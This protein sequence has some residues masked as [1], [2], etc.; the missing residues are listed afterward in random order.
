MAKFNQYEGALAW[1]VPPEEPKPKPRKKS[2]PVKKVCEACGFEATIRTKQGRHIN[3]TGL[4][5]GCTTFFG[6]AFPGVTNFGHEG[7]V[8]R[9]EQCA[10][11]K[12]VII[13][14]SGSFVDQSSGDR[15]SVDFGDIFPVNRVGSDRKPDG[16]VTD[17]M[18]RFTIDVLVN[19]R[20]LKLLPHEFAAIPWVTIMLYKK[21]GDYSEAFLGPNDKTGYFAPTDEV[22][23]MITNAFGER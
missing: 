7:T 11:E 13:L 12:H 14:K 16:K 10:E 21:E 22:K 8:E 9:L 2:T 3:D 4:C 18:D 15:L 23:A 20:P 1:D 5:L 19:N 17:A 6:G